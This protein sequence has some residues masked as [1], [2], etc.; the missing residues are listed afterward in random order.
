M[1]HF[2]K[3]LICLFHRNAAGEQDTL[4]KAR[5]HSANCRKRA[6][7]RPDSRPSASSG[8]A[9]H[10]NDLRSVTPGY[11]LL[12]AMIAATVLLIGLTATLPSVYQETQRE[13]EKEL[14]FRGKQYA[15]AI[16]LFHQKFQRYP[17]TIEE[18]KKPTNGWRFLRKEFP[19]PMTRGGKWRFIH[20]NAQ[21]VMLDSKTQP[22]AGGLGQAGAGQGA[23]GFGTSSTSIMGG[24]ILGQQ[25][26]GGSG[27]GQSA[28]GFSLDSGSGGNPSGVQQNSAFSSA[29]NQGGGT[30]I[31]GVASTSHKQ[32]IGIW[33]KKTHY[34]EWEFIAVDLGAL[35]IMTS[36]PC[37]PQAAGQQSGQGGATGS[38]GGPAQG[39][40]VSQGQNQGM[41]SP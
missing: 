40:P 5:T 26:A 32:S 21:G 19:D 30:F 12:F 25:S 9:L 18:L 28:G 17:A 11:A 36:S 6:V 8:Q 35:G 39:N 20:A 24:G 37:L 38:F 10:G 41:L 34:D 31:V 2:T 3:M 27:V 29:G 4:A 13:R 33:N 16:A 7:Y 1:L 23:S 14:I 15:R 22:L